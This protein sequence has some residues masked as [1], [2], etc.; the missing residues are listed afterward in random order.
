MTYYAI[1]EDPPLGDPG[2][3]QSSIFYNG[4][5]PVQGQS[6][7]N[8]SAPIAASSSL[9]A[10]WFA[11]ATV[12][13]EYG[14]DLLENQ[15]L[16]IRGQIDLY[17]GDSDG[18]VNF[19]EA[20]DFSAMVALARNWTDASVG[21]CCTFDYTP[22]SAPSGN[23]VSVEPPEVGPVNASN[24]TW[25]WSE[26][27]NLTGVTDGRTMRILDLPRVG[28][29]IE[30]IPLS[31]TLPENWEVQFSP[32]IEIFS[33]EPR[34]FTVDRSQASVAYDIRI[35]IGENFPPSISASRFPAT[36]SSI[37]LDT[38]SSFSAVCNDGPLESPVIE[39]SVSKDEA[40][41][42]T[43]QNPWFDF[44]PADHG[45]SHGDVASV[46]ASCTDSH[47]MASN[48]ND[49]VG[50]DGVLPEW[51]GVLS[52]VTGSEQRVHDLSEFVVEVDAGSEVIFDVNS[53]DETGLPVKLELFTNI[54]D[55]WRQLGVQQKSFQF[56]ANQGAGVNGAHLGIEERHQSKDPTS[57]S[58][59][60]QLSDDAGNIAY[61]EWEIRVLDANPPTI[62]MDVMV[63]G[64]LLKP[65]DEVHEN[66][67]IQ[68]EFSKS[69]DDLDAIENLTWTVSVDGT[70]LVTNVDWSSIETLDVNS[71]Q[72]GLGNHEVIASATDSSG[73][74]R[75]ELYDLL[76]HPKRG[77]H[78]VVTDQSLSEVTDIASDGCYPC[79]VNFTIQ[80]ENQGSD[81]SFARVCFGG[82][83][84]RYEEFPGATLEGG[85]PSSTIEFEFVLVNE[86]LEGLKV[87]WDSAIAGTHGEI[88][89]EYS[90]DQ[91][92]LVSEGPQSESLVAVLLL[93]IAILYA[94]RKSSAD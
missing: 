17:L 6:F 21:G 14:T 40:I 27:A 55:G 11:Q 74:T 19:S 56:T 4:T 28:A 16:G 25:G 15:S 86:S 33:G 70:D 79:S 34:N 57:Y 20:N 64:I 9:S 36:S 88:P 22:M 84:S 80:I 61:Q 73:N 63:N 49:N 58:M 71:L 46:L 45:F 94:I 77:A 1:P 12:S 82:N 59:L 5:D 72:L 87:E 31:I 44:S 29:L 35:T 75:T 38:H 69:F 51:T 30:E 67:E 41:L 39:W 78:L 65:D 43:F 18:W 76:V 54:S 92:T 13:D 68:L 8:F 3:H 89:L 53:S 62:M 50:I 10:T 32:M 26:S 60:L 7:L 66:D 90:I 2:A 23:E 24:G 37:P 85:P 42:A 47:G 93:T 91:G 52:V 48:W 83:C 81:P